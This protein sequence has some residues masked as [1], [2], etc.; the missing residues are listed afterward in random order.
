MSLGRGR[1]EK[2]SAWLEKQG[3]HGRENL[4]KRNPD[5]LVEV[6]KKLEA[7]LSVLDNPLHGRDRKARIVLNEIEVLH[8]EYG[9]ELH[10]M[11]KLI[12]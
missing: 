10:E 11:G 7:C 1:R 8:R 2:L 12:G 5:V 4:D 3:F 6:R 9:P